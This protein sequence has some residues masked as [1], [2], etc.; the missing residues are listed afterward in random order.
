[1]DTSHV[2]LVDWDGRQ[3][4]S[5][6]TTGPFPSPFPSYIVQVTPKVKSL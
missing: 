6:A 1:M 3:R 4:S 5:P 2:T